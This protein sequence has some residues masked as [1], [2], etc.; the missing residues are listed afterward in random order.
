M[1]FLV[2]VS[3]A[4]ILFLNTSCGKVKR[5]VDSY[6]DKR[7]TKEEEKHDPRS[8][9]ETDPVFYKYIEDFKDGYGRS[10]GDVPICLGIPYS[11]EVKDKENVVGVCKRWTGPT[12]RYREIIIKGEWYEDNKDDE[13]AIRQLLEHELGHCVL[14]RGHTSDLDDNLEPVSI[15]Y[16]YIFHG[17]HYQDNHQYYLDEL[18]GRL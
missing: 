18:F 14:G 5:N 8:G 12:R 7:I 15:M 6:V 2:L 1:R 10:I 11:P 17:T 4:I 3:L 13:Y 16:P 9:C